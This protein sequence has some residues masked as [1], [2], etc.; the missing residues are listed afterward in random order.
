M[1]NKAKGYT[2]I[3]KVLYLKYTY[4]RLNLYNNFLVNIL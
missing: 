4:Y 3:V 2:Q 1:Y